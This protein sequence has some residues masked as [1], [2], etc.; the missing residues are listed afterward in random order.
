MEKKLDVDIAKKFLGGLGFGVKVLY[1]EVRPNIDPLSPDNLIIIANGPLTATAAPT[2]GRTEIVTKSP[3]TGGIGTGNFG[4]WWGTRLKLSGFDAVI[5]RGKSDRPVYLWVEDGLVEVRSAE[6]LWGKDS[7]ETIDTLKEE[8]GDDISVLCIGQA[9]ENLVRFACPVADYHHAPGRSHAGCVMGAKKL[10]AIAVRATKGTVA[11]AEPKQFKEAVKEIRERIASYPERGERLKTG[12]NYLNKGAAELGI[13]P[14]RNFQTSVVP[15]ESEIWNF[16]KSVEDYTT[17]GPEFGSNCPMSR[18][19][20]CNLVTTIKTGQYAGRELGGVFLSF[21][22]WAWGSNCGIRSFPA[23]WKCRELCQRYGMDFSGPVA[24]AMELFQRGIITK[25]DT[26]GLELEW[27]NELAVME[28]LRKIAYREGFGDILAEG[29]LRAAKKI[30]KGADRYTL[31]IKGKQVQYFDPRTRGYAK[32]LGMIVGPRGDDLNTTHGIL[33]TFP[34]WAK[35][36]GWRKD[37]YVRWFVDWIDMFQEV[38]KKIFGIPPR[39]DALDSRAVEGK[40]ALTKWHGEI[41]S[42]YNSLDLCLFAAN[43]FAAVGPTHFAKLYSACTG[44]H[45]PPSKI[46]K[47][48]ERIFNLMKAYIVREGFTRQDD[49]WPRRFYEEPLPEG[50]AKGGV[51]SEY[52][53]TRL[54]DEYYEL[55]GWDKD[56]G[57][58][59]K[60]KLVELGLEEVANE[61]ESMGKLANISR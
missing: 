9:G 34:E 15:P 27:G 25:E 23:M 2:S 60:E 13:L 52:D 57:L 18:Y 31:T 37:E 28:M 24:F 3:L 20:G 8:L 47:A 5:V 14:C 10:K 46:M 30:G 12:S 40:A 26:D 41:A 33:E 22:G 43:T 17:M 44:W 55:M 59:T 35:K 39:P 32:N 49:D 4:S 53:V 51:L 16:P 19:Y 48:G 11:I 21:D 36:A 58:P 42:V 7:W 56:S 1:E 29:S 45:T 38:K 6:H 54:L 61:L 50:P